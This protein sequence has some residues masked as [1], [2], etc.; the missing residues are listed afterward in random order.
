M[1]YQFEGYYDCVDIAVLPPVA[2]P[3]LNIAMRPAI[4]TSSDY[5]RFAYPDD[6]AGERP[7]SRVDHCQFVRRTLGKR[8]YGTT[9]AT[10][11]AYVAAE[12][13]NKCTGA[14]DMSC[15]ALHGTM[16]WPPTKNLGRGRTKSECMSQCAGENQPRYSI[17]TLD[18]NGQGFC[19]CYGWS[20]S[21]VNWLSGPW[22]GVPNGASYESVGL[23]S[24]GI[25]VQQS[26]YGACIAIPPTGSRNSLNQTAHEALDAC[27]ARG[28]N[29]KAD[30]LNVV[31]IV[32]PPLAQL[33]V[34]DSSIP[35]T[36]YNSGA[37]F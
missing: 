36:Y 24:C 8:N 22:I 15:D 5:S 29:M 20:A 30:G 3:P 32:A 6:E 27:K 2:V 19:R 25:E 9:L 31:P 21:T 26:A 37:Y 34:A 28:R 33:G 12:F 10:S 1:H 18:S 11:A 35:S 7:F 13:K 23:S 4:A 14:S 17:T 16:F